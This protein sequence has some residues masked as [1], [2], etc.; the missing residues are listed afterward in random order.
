MT[1]PE[2]RDYLT[3]HLNL[4]GRR[5]QR[6]TTSAAT[7]SGGSLG[8]RVPP[9]RWVPNPT[10]TTTCGSSLL[11]AGDHVVVGTEWLALPGAG[12]QVKDA[13]GLYGEVGI[14][15][16]DP[17]P[18]LPGLDRV[19]GEDAP[20][21]RRRDRVGDPGG[22]D[23]KGEVQAGPRGQRH[24]VLCGQFAGQ[25]YDLGPLHLGEQPRATRPGQVGQTG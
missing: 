8:S 13:F 7:R 15:D 20:H 19:V 22:G 5:Q 23:F 14:A 18:V 21:G 9:G 16:R 25:R 10:S 2:T 6:R 11:V 17:G 12:V 4:A 3:H 1:E 24:A